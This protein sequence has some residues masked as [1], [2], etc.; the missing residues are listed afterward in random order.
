VWAAAFNDV[1]AMRVWCTC[2]IGMSTQYTVIIT[3]TTTIYMLSVVHMN[4]PCCHNSACNYM[5]IIAIDPFRCAAALKL[6]LQ[7]GL[8]WQSVL[9][10][11]LRPAPAAGMSSGLMLY[12][13]FPVQIHRQA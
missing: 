10:A 3:Y 4:G 8:T 6:A 1:R 9:Q 11:I 13:A 7:L 12:R 5:T 2:R